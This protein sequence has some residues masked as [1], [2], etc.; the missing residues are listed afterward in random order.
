MARAAAALA[1]F[2]GAG[3]RF[4][5]LGTTAAGALV[6]DDYAHH[7]TEVA[8]DD[9]RRAHARAAPRRRALPAAPVLAH[10][11]RGAARSARRSPQAD[12]A[13]VLDIYPARESAEDYPGV[14]GLLVAEA[15]ADAAGGKRVV[16]MRTHAARR[17][18]PARASCGPATCC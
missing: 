13:V 11:A 6:V 1:D 2:E 17:V 5:R 4:E 18:V 15:A 8:R 3:R 12:L 7:P 14:T 16:W 10:A 9:R